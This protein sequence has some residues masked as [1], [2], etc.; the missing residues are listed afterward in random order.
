MGRMVLAAPLSE[1]RLP[2]VLGVAQNTHDEFL[3]VVANGRP[4][5]SRGRRALRGRR[6]RA[7][8]LERVQHVQWV[9]PEEQAD[10]HDGNETRAAELHA[11]RAPT[12][13]RA[14]AL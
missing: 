11:P 13:R 8:A 14:G 3:G 7:A 2:G 5:R 6:G 4:G 12:S 10:D 9:E 1:E